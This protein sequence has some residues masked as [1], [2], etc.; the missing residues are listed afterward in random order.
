TTPFNK[1]ELHDISIHKITTYH[2]STQGNTINL[3]TQKGNTVITPL[4]SPMTI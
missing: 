2:N 1:L 3:P 4:L